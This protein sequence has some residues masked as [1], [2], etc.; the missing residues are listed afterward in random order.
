M[1]LLLRVKLIEGFAGS[2]SPFLP[3]YF[4]SAILLGAF[5]LVFPVFD[6][7]S[8]SGRIKLVSRIELLICP[9]IILPALW[10]KSN[11]NKL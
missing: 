10:V 4:I 2:C 6:E 3:Q 7:N 5:Q 1:A 9:K 8:Y 11:R